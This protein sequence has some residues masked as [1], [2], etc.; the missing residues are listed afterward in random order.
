MSD[1][2]K[3]LKIA[4]SYIGTPYL[5]GGNTPKGFDCS[6][7]VQYV[8]KEFGINIPRTTYDQI[9]IGT[10]INDKSKLQA[11]DLIF[12]LDKN[13]S[14][15][16]VF[17]YS[18]DNKVIEAK[19]TGTLI[20]QHNSWLWHGVAVRIIN[21]ISKNENISASQDKKLYYRVVAGS[22]NNKSLALEQQ[23]KLKKSGYDSFLDAF[24][25]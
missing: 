6:G 3:L 25:V 14:P 21:D 24:Y 16:H 8:Y 4:R 11:G 13:N 20:S 22:F 2:E 9:N 5:Y 15:Y 10:K 18:E 7:F 19:K 12:N 1:K 17:M 23:E